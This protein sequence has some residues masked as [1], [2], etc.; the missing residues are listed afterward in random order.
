MLVV[1]LLLTEFVADAL[2]LH[3]R[4]VLEG[5]PAVEDLGVVGE[6][7]DP[8]QCQHYLVRQQ[9]V[10]PLTQPGD[11]GPVPAVLWVAQDQG[12]S[13]LAVLTWRRILY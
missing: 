8:A 5:V 6:R 3:E 2:V 11:D 12:P 1:L 7:G 13:V 9:G 4:G 10:G